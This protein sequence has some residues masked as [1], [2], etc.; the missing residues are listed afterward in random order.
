MALRNGVPITEPQPV[1]VPEKPHQVPAPTSYQLSLR[2]EPP[3]IDQKHQ[4]TKPALDTE[5][6]RKKEA[7]AALSRKRLLH[8]DALRK[9]DGT[10]FVLVMGLRGFEPRRMSYSVDQIRLSTRG[11]GQKAMWHGCKSSVMFNVKL[12]R[13]E[14]ETDSMGFA[15]SGLYDTWGEAEAIGRERANSG[16]D[17]SGLDQVSARAPIDELRR[18]RARNHP[19]HHADADTALY[20][21]AVHA[22]DALRNGQCQGTSP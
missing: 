18:I 9:P 21:S 22:L 16:D 17:I 8:R 13:W 10:Y 7:A 11:K 14:I 20:Q 3:E 5:T 1:A 12:D 2:N 19:D 15:T 4:A 6:L